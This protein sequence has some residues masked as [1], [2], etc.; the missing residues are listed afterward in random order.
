MTV[1]GDQWPMFLYANQVYDPDDP[2]CGLFRSQLLL[3]ASI[4]SILYT[5]LLTV[6]LK[7]RLNISSLRPV[8]WKKK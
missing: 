8:L 4:I 7:R 5:V 1:A 6:Q 2:W 3:Y